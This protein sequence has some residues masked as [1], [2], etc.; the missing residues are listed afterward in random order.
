[1][2]S[3]AHRPKAALP[4]LDFISVLCMPGH[5]RSNKELNDL[6]I[7]DR[8]RVF[9]DL[10]GSGKLKEENVHE[11][12]EAI[13]Q[14]GVELSK[15]PRNMDAYELACR[16]N[17]DYVSDPAFLLMFLRGNDYDPSD[18]AA[19]LVAHFAEKL[20]L[21][22]EDKLTKD[23]ELS[24]LSE[25]DMYSLHSGGIQIG[26]TKDQAGRLVMFMRFAEYRWK[27]VDNWVGISSAVGPSLSI[28]RR[29]TRVLVFCSAVHLGT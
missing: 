9:E 18:S 11:L 29:L 22:G 28:R 16:L 24:D 13:R 21:F 27:S 15:M 10:A 17:P 4:L 6:P 25:D 8:T 23:I 14:M 7:N 20:K 12:A 5:H 3:P 19:Q 1:M 26:N 2:M